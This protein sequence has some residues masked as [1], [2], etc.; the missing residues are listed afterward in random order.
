[1]GSFF[2][3]AGD[4]SEVSDKAKSAWGDFGGRELTISARRPDQTRI[5][6]IFHIVIQRLHQKALD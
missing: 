6:N 5:K 1:M 2:L 3:Q 4:L